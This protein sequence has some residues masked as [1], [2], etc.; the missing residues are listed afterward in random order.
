MSYSVAGGKLKET[1]TSHWFSPNTGATDEVG[2]SALPGG[3]S[4]WT[5]YPWYWDIGYN[6][7]WWYLP[8]AIQGITNWDLSSGT[9]E[10]QLGLADENP[11]YSVRCVKNPGKR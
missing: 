8:E 1:G 2:F 10:V 3:R 7:Y 11:S 6:G 4:G 5:V 9:D